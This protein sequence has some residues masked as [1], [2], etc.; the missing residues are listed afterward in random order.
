MSSYKDNPFLSNLLSL[1][2]DGSGA[3]SAPSNWDERPLLEV[4]TELDVAIDCIA[5][6]LL[7]SSGQKSTGTWWFL[8]GSP[9]NGKSAAVGRLVRSIRDTAGAS[10]RLEKDASG[11]LGQDIKDLPPNQIPYKVELYE[12][13]ETYASAWFAQDASVV[14]NPFAE[15]ADPATELEELV[16]SA[17]DKGVSLVVCANRGV[18]EKTCEI[19]GRDPANKSTPWYRAIQAASSGHGMAGLALEPTARNPVCRSVDVDV[20]TLDADSLLPNGTFAKIIAEAVAETNWE[21]CAACDASPRCPFKQNREWLALAEGTDRLVATLRMAELFSGQIIVFREAVA[22]VSLMLAGC[23]IDYQNQSPCDWVRDKLEANAVF[24]L[25]SRRLYSILFNSYSPFGLEPDGDDQAN[26]LNSISE[27][28]QTRPVSDEASAGIQCMTQ[29]AHSVSA[30]VGITRLLGKDGILRQLDPVKEGQGRELEQRWDASPD[31]LLEIDQQLISELEI[32]CFEIWKQL[33]V[34]LENYGDK[35]ID[36]YR[37]LRRWITSV[38]F[39][40]GFFAE[41]ELLFEKELKTLDRIIESKDEVDSPERDLH[42]AEISEQLAKMLSITDEG[43]E[44]GPFVN[45]RGSWVSSLMDIQVT[46]RASRSG[47]LEAT[48]G[49]V[50][51]DLSAQVYAWLDRRANTGLAKITFPDDI[52]Q[53]AKDIRHRAATSSKY[54]FSKGDVRLQILLPASNQKLEL[55]RVR[56]HA[57]VR[58][59]AE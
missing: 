59:V 9:G 27:L 37:W 16:R 5:P 21:I 51:F 58:T 4:T 46:G 29:A 44:I 23:P 10:F 36:A 56:N 8:V 42:L 54:A 49:D 15:N 55:R 13:G 24:S 52:L 22:L 17:N 1:Q 47:G 12:S 14:K 50:P 57:I 40:L 26:Q 45:I 25:L 19:A 28:S 32:G 38:T 3:I 34:G 39:R 41:G 53:V 20:T 48:V 43:I 31:Q 7:S 35:T 11:R 6:K 30:D 2:Q 18:L 33:E